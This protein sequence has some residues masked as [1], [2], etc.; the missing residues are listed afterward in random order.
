M[1]FPMNTPWNLRSRKRKAK[2]LNNYLY[3]YNLCHQCEK[4]ILKLSGYVLLTLEKLLLSKG[5]IPTASERH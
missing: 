5:F 1:L 2:R 4:F 3:D